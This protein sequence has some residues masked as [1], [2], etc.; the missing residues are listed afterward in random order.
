M[1]TD[2]LI[3]DFFQIINLFQ[4]FILVTHSNPDIDGI[5]SMLS[6]HL[7]LKSLNKS[8]FPLIED[9]PDDIEILSPSEELILVDNF[10]LNL[11]DFA[12]IVLDT[13]TPER[14]PEKI[15]EKVSSSKFFIIIDHHQ[16]NKKDCLFS[17]N[18]LC[19]IDTSAPSTTY[20]VYEILKGGGFDFSPELAQNLLS[21]LYFD[22]GCFKY[23]NVNENTFAVA[24]ELCKLGAKPH[25][26][27]SY[28]FENLSLKDIEVLKLILERLEFFQNGIIAVS[29]LTYQD[30][31][32]FGSQK[33]SDFSNFLRSIKGV[34]ISALIKEVEKNTVSVSLRS[35]APIEVYELAKSFGGGGHKYAC[36]FKIKVNNFYEFLNS[37]KETLRKYYGG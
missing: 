31:Q 21:G 34:K 36:G 7:V 16:L 11:K 30:I 15:Y 33:L 18:E 14:L 27:A 20:L 9:I 32:K 26:I 4:N 8:S 22:T 3:K 2:Q 17:E 25:I 35:R 10:N 13:N 1:K 5:S 37:F 6:L 12:T 23:E 19:I 29:Y 28:L 24:S